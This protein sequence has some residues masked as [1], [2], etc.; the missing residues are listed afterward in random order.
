MRMH[1]NVQYMY[2]TGASGL[3]RSMVLELF[4]TLGSGLGITYGS[5][6][7]HHSS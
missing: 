3:L 4:G 5:R 2:I 6:G 7:E 1:N